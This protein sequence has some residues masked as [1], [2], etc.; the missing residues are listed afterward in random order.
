MHLQKHLIEALL[1][2]T[3]YTIQHGKEKRNDEIF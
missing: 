1:D 2:N 3:D